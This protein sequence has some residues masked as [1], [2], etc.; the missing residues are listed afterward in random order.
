MG[1]REGIRGFLGAEVAR[2]LLEVDTEA[3]EKATEIRLRAD[4]PLILR[5]GGRDFGIGGGGRLTPVRL[6]GFC[7]AF[8][9]ISETMERISQYSF[10]AFEAELSMGYITLPGGHRVGVCG[11]AVVENGGVRSWRYI[12]GLNIR[13]A[14]SVIGCANEVLPIIVQKNELLH[15]MIISPPGF[16]KTTLLRDIIRQI[17]GGEGGLT[18]GLADERSEVA[19]C[20][21]GVPQNDLGLRTDVID[22]C[23]KAIGM[24]MLLRSMSPDVIIA[25]EIGRAAEVEVI[26]DIVNAGVRLICTAHGGSIA[27]LQGRRVLKELL[28]AGGFTRFVLLCKGETPGEI[29]GVYDENFNEL[30]RLRLGLEIGGTHDV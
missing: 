15:T 1:V 20:F 2:R 22:G 3:F 11:Q 29:V 26:T 18:V 17:S 30:T 9:D 16:G 27:D 14:H 13:L 28:S 10:Y 7:P 8:E 21:R 19:G 25:D 24:N 23:P 6:D 12:S 5:V 4:K